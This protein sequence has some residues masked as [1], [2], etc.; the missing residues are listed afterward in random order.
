LVTLASSWHACGQ[1]LLRAGEHYTCR[2]SSLP[3]YEAGTPL[4]SEPDDYW[5]LQTAPIA[6]AIPLRFRLEMFEDDDTE[7]PVGVITYESSPLQPAWD[8]FTCMSEGSGN[9]QDLQGAVRVTVLDGTL[10]L[11]SLW[12]TAWRPSGEGVFDVFYSGFITLAPKPRINILPTSDRQAEITWPTNFHGYVVETATSFSTARWTRLTNSV[13]AKE[14]LFSVTVG[15]EES[16]RL[17]R[18][19]KP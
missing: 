11:N 18:L 3:L 9:W 5:E 16:H 13:V 10:Q 1:I 17:F 15:T 8:A 7:D 14:G 2:F 19:A 6:P 12:V 4:D